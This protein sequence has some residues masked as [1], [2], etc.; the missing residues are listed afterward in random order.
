MAATVHLI[1][2][3]PREIR[4]HRVRGIATGNDHARFDADR[5]AAQLKLPYT[6]CTADQAD[7]VYIKTVATNKNISYQIGRG[8]A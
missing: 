4:P 5:G 2:D 7:T 3:I 6:F 1:S 8:N